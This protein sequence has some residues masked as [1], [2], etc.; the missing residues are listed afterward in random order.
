MIDEENLLA[1]VAY[2]TNA[3]HTGLLP[4]AALNV[5]KGRSP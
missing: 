3:I 5:P 4:Q 1:L 2:K